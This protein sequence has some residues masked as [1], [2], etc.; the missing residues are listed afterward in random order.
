MVLPQVMEKNELRNNDVS[1]ITGLTIG[2]AI[3]IGSA[4]YSFVY[5]KNRMGINLVKIVGNFLHK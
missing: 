3:F 4:F 5:L 2:G 1:H